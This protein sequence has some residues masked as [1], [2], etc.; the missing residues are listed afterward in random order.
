M[1]IRIE[2]AAVNG[3]AIVDKLAALNRQQVII[4]NRAAIIT[5]YIICKIGINEGGIITVDR[6][7]LQVRLIAAKGGI[8]DEQ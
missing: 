5:S 8:S 1:H 3:R 6:A 4:F 7:P 2:R